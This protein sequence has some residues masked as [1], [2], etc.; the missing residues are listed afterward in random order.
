MNKK[1]RQ[2]SLLVALTALMCVFAVPSWG[3][4]DRNY[5]PDPKTIEIPDLEKDPGYYFL[6]AEQSE[7]AGDA[8]GVLTYYKKALALDPTSAYL[9]TRIATLLAR[10]RKIADALVM[11]RSAIILDPDYEEAY[12]LLGKIYT[13]TGDRNRAVAAYGRALELK[14]G[15]RDL[16]VLLGSLQAS[17]RLLADAEKTFRTMIEQF[18]DEKEGYFYLGK[19]YVEDQKYDKATEI[20]KELL[21]KRGDT[22]PQAHVELGAVYALQKQYPDAEEQFREAVKLDPFNINARLSLGQVLASQ[23]KFDESYKVFEELAKLA[24]SNLGI[25]IKMALIL[26][27]QKNYDKAKEM[28]DGILQTKPGWDQVR[29]H[30]GRVLREQ[31][32]VAEAEKELTQI[33][34]GQPT[35]VNSRIMLAIMFLRS[36]D[37]GKA[38]RYINEAAEQDS[39]DSDIMHIKGSIL[40]ELNRFQEAAGV[41]EKALE[42]EPKSGRIRYSLGN[43]FEKSGRRTRGLQ[44]MERILADNPDDASAMNFIGYTLVVSGQDIPKAEKLIRRAMELKPGDGYILDS[45]AWV[46]FKTG[47]VDEALTNLQQAAE[48]V[49]TDPIVA[50]HLGDVLLEKNRKEEALEAYRRSLGVNPDNV[51]VQD[52]FRK[53]EEALKTGKQ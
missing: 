7:S 24:P 10:N 48:K 17:Q 34:K 26:A 29:F 5:S 3:S 39:K 33:K 37:L 35:F 53:L 16:Y 46:L 4:K 44:E 9:N 1:C 42:I 15:D 25:Q 27:E 18:P 22:A 40:E 19:V 20:F 23:K 52:K 50:E 11:A 30:L 8:E 12:T 2:V 14:P 49:K 41:Y 32:K 13:V 43:V 47:K 31:G 6:M 38:I 21:E 51:I 28:L 36:K 45:M